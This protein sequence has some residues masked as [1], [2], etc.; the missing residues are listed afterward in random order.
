MNLKFI[1]EQLPYA[2]HITSDVIVAKGKH[3]MITNWK[4][5]KQ[6]IQWLRQRLK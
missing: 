1:L 4:E 3:K 2:D 6:H 5:A